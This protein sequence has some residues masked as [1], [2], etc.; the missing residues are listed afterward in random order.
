MEGGNSREH[1]ADSLDLLTGKGGHAES[2]RGD[3]GQDWAGGTQFPSGKGSRRGR[4]V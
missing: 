2:G 4:P 1:R 3:G